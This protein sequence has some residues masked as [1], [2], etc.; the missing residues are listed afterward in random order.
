MAIRQETYTIYVK[1][2]IDIEAGGNPVKIFA[3]QNTPLYAKNPISSTGAN[4]ITH[5]EIKKE[6]TD[7]FWQA[8]YT[9][10]SYEQIRVKYKELLNDIGE[11]YIRVEKNVF[12]DFNIVPNS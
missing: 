2:F 12:I 9:S 5:M 4:P 11:E 10:N 1:P 8:Y 6:P 7:E 3:E